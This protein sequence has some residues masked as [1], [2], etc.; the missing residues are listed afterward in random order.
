M[1]KTLV[2]FLCVGGKY[3]KSYYIRIGFFFSNV[4]DHIQEKKLWRDSAKRVQQTIGMKLELVKDRVAR[5]CHFFAN[6][7]YI[8]H[9]RQ[10]LLNIS[11]NCNKSLFFGRI[12]KAITKQKGFLGILVFLFFFFLFAAGSWFKFK[13]GF[14]KQAFQ[15]TVFSIIR[16]LIMKSALDFFVQTQSLNF[17]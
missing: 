7:A 6:R 1:E 3:S 17:F 4:V 16:P 12:P 5:V 9:V 2:Y 14:K 13:K 11:I 10:K 15:Q 8:P